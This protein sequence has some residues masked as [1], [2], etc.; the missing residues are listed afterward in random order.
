MTPFTFVHCERNPKPCFSYTMYEFDTRTMSGEY[1]SV[2]SRGTPRMKP[3]YSTCVPHLRF[4]KRKL[5]ECWST[6]R[7]KTTKRTTTSL[8][9]SLNTKRPRRKTMEIQVLA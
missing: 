8:L 5:T 7:P 6:I 4:M 1:R 9:K 3:I 2:I